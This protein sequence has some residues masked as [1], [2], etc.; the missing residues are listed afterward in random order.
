MNKVRLAVMGPE[1]SGKSSVIKW[2]CTVKNGFEVETELSNQFS[3][4]GEIEVLS[5]M[6]SVDGREYLIE[7]IEV[8]SNDVCKSKLTPRTWMQQVD[9]YIFVV[10]I[11]QSNVNSQLWRLHDCVQ[12]MDQGIQAPT[13]TVSD[14]QYLQQ[15]Q[16]NNNRREQHQGQKRLPKSLSQQSVTLRHT[17][18]F[19]NNA[20]EVKLNLT[21]DTHTKQFNLMVVATHED[22]QVGR[23]GATQMLPLDF[24]ESAG[25][26]FTGLSTLTADGSI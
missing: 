4:S 21:S 12:E 23:Y 9:G 14:Y 26:E 8:P 22:L 7:L 6:S 24:V 1:G 5:H 11:M 2:L 10:N 16:I 13:L 19:S 3:W 25:A 17:P 15:Q 20:N 18:S